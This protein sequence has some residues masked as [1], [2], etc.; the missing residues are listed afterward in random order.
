[1]S[2]V[3]IDQEF[4]ALRLALAN[5]PEQGKFVELFH[6]YNRKRT[7]IVIFVNMFQQATGQAFASQYGAIFIKGLGTINPFDMTLINAVYNSTTIM[8]CL[9]LADKVGR[10]YADIA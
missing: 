5:E 10:R 3:E 1:L 9:F 4:E 6:G 7:L 2:D 8:F